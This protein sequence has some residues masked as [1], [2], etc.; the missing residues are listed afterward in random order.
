M[1]GFKKFL[2]RGNVVDLAVA[3]VIGAAFTTVI[4]SFVKG[5]INP[6]VGALGTKDLDSYRSCLKGPCA[7]DA[8]GNVTQGVFI[9][10]GTVLSALLTFV[11]TA[12]VVYFIFVLPINHM[13]DRRARALGQAKAERLTDNELLTEIRDLLA[14]QPGPQTSGAGSRT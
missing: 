5:V 3:V 8:A 11:I 9:L 1:G 7:V 12:L 2:M 10:W 4:N 14:E 6:L 13:M